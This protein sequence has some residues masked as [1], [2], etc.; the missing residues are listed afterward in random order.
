MTTLSLPNLVQCGG[1]NVIRY[2]ALESVDAPQLTTIDN[3]GALFFESNPNLTSVN[4]PSLRSTEMLTFQRNPKLSGTLRLHPNTTVAQCSILFNC[5]VS[6]GNVKDFCP[7][8][9]SVNQPE[10]TAAC[11]DCANPSNIGICSSTNTVIVN[12]FR[13]YFGDDTIC[14]Q[15]DR[16]PTT[17]ANDACRVSIVSSNNDIDGMQFSFSSCSAT[18]SNDNI[19][20]MN[21][22]GGGDS[23]T[24]TQLNDAA[25]GQTLAISKDPLPSSRLSVTSKVLI[26][27]NLAPESPASTLTFAPTFTSTTTQTSA[28]TQQEPT[29]T[30][31]FTS[32]A[33]VTVGS[34][35]V[36]T[37][38]SSSSASSTSGPTQTQDG[39]LNSPSSESEDSAGSADDVCDGDQ[40]GDGNGDCDD[41]ELLLEMVKNRGADLPVRVNGQTVA[42][43]EISRV[44]ALRG[45]GVSRVRV[46]EATVVGIAQQLASESA[47]TVT[48]V[49][50]FGE[51]VA[52]ANLKDSDRLQI[53][54]RPTSETI[55]NDNACLAFFDDTRLSNFSVF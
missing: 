20:A 53:C 17:L 35:Q 10:A 47:I 19:V 36:Q 31:S 6:N 30:T 25:C 37:T 26:S 43:V 16:D 52:V 27:A 9:Q 28:P 39:T 4:V 55:S 8:S 51:N 42:I 40:D 38:F 11:A 13:D 12:S 49:D 34:S 48:A 46:R 24:L 15:F 44:A 41:D 50:M 1:L 7:E 32:T 14:F 23:I 22:Q 5:F 33:S 18:F 29:T 3:G 21:L 45:I 2:S 54:L